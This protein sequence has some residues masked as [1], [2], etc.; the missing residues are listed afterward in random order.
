MW[1]L[2]VVLFIEVEEED[3]MG[4]YGKAIGVWEL[5]V[6]GAELDLHP[7][8]GDNKKLMDILMSKQHKDNSAAKM[9]QFG[10]FM[11]ELIKR[12]YPP[13]DE[14]EIQEL[15]EYVEFNLMDLFKET[16]IVFKWSTKEA[17]E[18]AE[19]E[20]MKELKKSIGGA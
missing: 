8:M 11:Q 9:E 18:K 20:S 17:M 2:L 1:R 7:R 5:R 13:I 14:A 10:K 6:G 3:K 4:K 19:Q 16:M 15:S 12:E